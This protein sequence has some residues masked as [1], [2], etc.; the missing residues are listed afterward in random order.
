MSANG[1]NDLL[2]SLRDSENKN[3][4]EIITILHQRIAELK[5]EIAD[6]DEIINKQSMY[7]METFAHEYTYKISIWYRIWQFF[8]W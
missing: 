3:L 6:R 5:Q 2:T 4:H 8:N 7:V 1:M